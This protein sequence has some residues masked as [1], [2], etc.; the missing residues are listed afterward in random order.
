M[1]EVDVI[2]KFFFGF[3]KTLKVVFFWVIFFGNFFFWGICSSK[4]AQLLPCSI[5]Y[6][7]T[8]ANEICSALLERI[9][10][11]TSNS[12]INICICVYM[13]CSIDYIVTMANEICLAL[14]E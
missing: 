8:M 11:Y 10:I 12:Y 4:F 6:V 9:H 2:C 5:N 3:K 13:P 7:V 14:L 1:D